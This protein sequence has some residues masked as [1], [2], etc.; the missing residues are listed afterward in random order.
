MI[1]KL[2]P[3]IKKTIWGGDTLSTRFSYIDD[4][5]SVGEVWTVSGLKHHANIIENTDYKGKTLYD[6]WQEARHLFGNK[7]GD[8]FPLLVKFIDA[9]TD[10]SIQVHPNDKEAKKKNALGKTECWTILDCIPDTTII[11][12][13]KAPTKNAIKDA[14]DN[15]S[16]LDIVNHYPIKPGDF[17]FIK[18][19]TLH[20]IKGGTTLLEVQQSSDI[21][22]RLYDYNRLEN[23]KPR[24]LHIDD[25]L[26]CITVPDNTVHQTLEKTYFDLTIDNLEGKTSRI[27]HKHGDF[28]TV[29][30]GHAT[31]NDV[32]VDQGISVFVSA[33]SQYEIHGNVTIA[34]SN[35]M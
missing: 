12:G 21:T 31:I 32:H 23:G 28:I 7:P 1:L 8:L 34:I 33:L 10:L 24:P 2:Q 3:I 17:F 27:A 18:P 35:M 15:D 5:T 26:Q 4:G 13:H 29:L 20:A 11:I 9:K 14:L 6:V 30:R 19:G 16:I 25:A 22:Y